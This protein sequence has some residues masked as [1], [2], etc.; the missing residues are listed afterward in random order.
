MERKISTTEQKELR[1]S[2]KQ[3]LEAICAWINTHINEHIGWDELSRQSKRS[4]K[5][6]IE[7]F[8]QINT[9]P[10]AYIR[11]IK[12]TVK[13]NESIKAKTS[14]IID[15]IQRTGADPPLKRSNLITHNRITERDKSTLKERTDRSALTL[16]NNSLRQ[17]TQE[18]HS[19]T[20]QIYLKRKQQITL[21]IQSIDAKVK[22]TLDN[23]MD[24]YE[25]NTHI[26]TLQRG[27]EVRTVGLNND[28]F[29]NTGD[30]FNISAL[31]RI[32]TA[33]NEMRSTKGP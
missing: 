29:Y 1:A 24:M 23:D 22:V 4:H 6:L 5:D 32:M 3:E 11:Y 17:G 26:V 8:R 21:Q 16:N 13:L 15:D 19:D 14:R 9:T 12:E 27:I 25:S 10:M 2:N 20:T 18:I 28:E 7:L 30:Q 31:L 33:I